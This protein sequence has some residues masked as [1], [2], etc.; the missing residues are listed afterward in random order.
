[1]LLRAGR[2]RGGGG[3]RRLRPAGVVAAQRPPGAACTTAPT[4]ATSTAE[5]VGG[6]VDL[7]VGDLSFISLTLV[8]DALVGVDQRRRRP[9]ADGQ[10]AVRGGQGPAGQGR[11]GPRPGA[12]GPAPWSRCGRRGRA[13]GLGSPR[14]HRQ[15]AAGPVGQR[16]V[17]RLAAARA[18]AD[19]GRDAVEAEVARSASWGVPV[20]RWTRDRTGRRA[21]PGR[22]RRILLLAHTGREE[23]REVTPARWSARC[24]PTACACGCS[25]TRPRSST[26]ARPTASRSVAAEDA[27]CE[28]C[29]L[30]VVIGGDGTILRA[31]ELTHGSTHAAAR[32]Q[33]R[34][35]RLPRR[36]RERGRRQHHRA[37]SSSGATP[38]RSG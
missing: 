1:M 32:R 10:A 12:T 18:R 28:Q 25:T 22:A 24:A 13:R 5:L 20:R 26:S 6:P 7:V 2:A 36:G 31:A 9:G 14:G 17:L 29:E 4:S 8:L 3:R 34:P 37:R 35:R 33:P 19:V 11:R 27:A 38:A 30:A 16:R 15:P 23:A 21:A